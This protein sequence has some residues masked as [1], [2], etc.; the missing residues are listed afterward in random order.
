MVRLSKL[1]PCPFWAEI[2]KSVQPLPAFDFSLLLL[3][4][5]LGESK[6]I[7]REDISRGSALAVRAKIRAQH[8]DLIDRG[9]RDAI[10]DMLGGLSCATL[11]E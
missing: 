8:G 5:A 6:R 3:H 4:S 10:G 7:E 1:K 9:T 2:G 11:S